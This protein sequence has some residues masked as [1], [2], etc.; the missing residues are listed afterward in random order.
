MARRVKRPLSFI[1]SDTYA[2]FHFHSSPSLPFP[3]IGNA[4]AWSEK[5]RKEKSL[6]SSETS[7]N[8]SK[9]DANLQP[10]LSLTHSPVADI[11]KTS[12]KFS[13]VNRFL[14]IFVLNV[15]PIATK[16]Y[17]VNWSIFFSL[18]S[19]SPLIFHLSSLCFVTAILRIFIRYIRPLSL[20]VCVCVCHLIRWPRLSLS[21]LTNHLLPMI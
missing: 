17:K 10:E 8:D 11:S 20:H 18:L 1:A 16:V 14:H 13:E 6:S 3:W 5:E 4:P 2:H 9:Y 12:L 7:A 19:C 15:I 21:S